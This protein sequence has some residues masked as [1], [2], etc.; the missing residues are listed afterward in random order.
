MLGGAI[1]R[2]LMRKLSMAFEKW[3]FTA[4]QLAREK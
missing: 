3:Q 1:K 2:M 4:N